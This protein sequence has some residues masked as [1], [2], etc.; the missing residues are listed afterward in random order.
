MKISL[1]KPIQVGQQYETTG[2]SDLCAAAEPGP[3]PYEVS[4]IR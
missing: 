3:I 1:L 4:H 2:S